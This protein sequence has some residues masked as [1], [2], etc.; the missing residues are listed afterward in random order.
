[1]KQLAPVLDI[2][3][4]LAKV[5]ICSANPRDLLALGNRWIRCRG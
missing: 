2:E 3:R 4:L 1:V 5:V